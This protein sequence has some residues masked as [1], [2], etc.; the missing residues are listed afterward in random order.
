M[1]T[2]QEMYD[3]ILGFAARDERIRAVILNGSRANPKA[4]KDPYQDYDIIYI[5]NEFEQFKS[6]YGWLD[7]FGERLIMQ[8]PES[9]RDPS[10]RGHFNWMML[11]S[12]G[13]RLDLTLIPADRLDLIGNDSLTVVLLDKDGILTPFPPADDRDYL[14]K[15][16]NE[17]CYYSCCN[18]FFWCMQ[19]VVK[20]IA[21]DELPYAMLM[22][23]QVVREELH[24]MITWYL[25]IQTNAS[26]SA[27][28]MGKYFKNYLPEDLY[29]MY[30]Q[31]YSDSDYTNMWNAILT[32][33][34][35]FRILAKEVSNAL[36]FSY[37]QSDDDGIMKYLDMVKTGTFQSEQMAAGKMS[38][39]ANGSAP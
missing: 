2:E 15:T 12:D 14:A 25:A 31:T 38:A 5:V 26:V 32:A 36:G 1:R 17:L 21:R 20:G 39:P 34:S 30:L 11:F 13:N 24:D 19:N 16:P 23:H 3:L 9:M 33:C 35:L 4:P 8:M 37:N 22:Y 29:D 6:D 28:K 7:I 27:G 18:N 10:G